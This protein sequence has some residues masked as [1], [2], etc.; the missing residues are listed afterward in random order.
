[1][2]IARLKDLSERERI[3]ELPGRSGGAEDAEPPRMA[4]GSREPAGEVGPGG[5]LPAPP[6][7]P[8]VFAQTHTKNPPK[9][10][11]KNEQI[12]I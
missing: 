11:K 3:E 9:H 7:T 1:M 5:G 6:C 8:P 2:E 4:G 10:P 12:K